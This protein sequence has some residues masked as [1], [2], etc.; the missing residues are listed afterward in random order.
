MGQDQ[1]A[2]VKEQ[3]R[4]LRPVMNSTWEFLVAVRYASRNAAA[5]MQV[6]TRHMSACPLSS[7][8]AC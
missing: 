7:S 2:N 8:G 3:M 1:I 5:A 6:K 4:I